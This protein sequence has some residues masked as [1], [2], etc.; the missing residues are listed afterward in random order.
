[1]LFSSSEKYSI[2]HIAVLTW[3]AITSSI[4]S[5]PIAI[6]ARSIWDSIS[7]IC[8]DLKIPMAVYVVVMPEIKNQL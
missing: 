3:K 6:F 1:M 5:F 2:A 8:E 4:L 7:W